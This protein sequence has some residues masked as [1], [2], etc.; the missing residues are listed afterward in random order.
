MQRTNIY[1]SDQQLDLLR[2]LADQ[3][4]VA[5]AELVRQAV[6]TWLNEQGARLIP[7]DEWSKRFEALLE[8]RRSIAQ[9][10]TPSERQVEWDVAA[11]VTSARSARAARRR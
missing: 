7:E 6:D 10:L 3:R 4:G 2:R 9:E 8:R 5:V 11:A 1:L